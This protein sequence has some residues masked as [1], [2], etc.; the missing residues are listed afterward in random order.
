MIITVEISHYPLMDNY[1]EDILL[2]IRK[3][4]DHPGLTVRTTAMSTYLKG[5][6]SLVFDVLSSS[7][8]VIF[9]K[10]VL[11]STIIKVIPRDLTIEDG[12]LK[13]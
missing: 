5:E 1:E 12:F 11:S 2:L 13:I 6:H 4:N 8:E 10:G 3:W 7:L 9:S